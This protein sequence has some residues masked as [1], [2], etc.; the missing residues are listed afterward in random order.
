M[1]TSSLLARR[2]VLEL[3]HPLEVAV[4]RDGRQQPAQLGVLAHVGLAEQDAALGIEPGGHQHR[5]RVEHVAG[6][7]LRVVGDARGVQVDDAVDRR[8][9]ALLALEVAPDRADVVAE[10]LAPGRLDA[11]ED[12]HGG[13]QSRDA[14][15]RHR[16][17]ARRR[18]S[19]SP[20]G[21]RAAR[22][23]GCCR[24][25]RWRARE[26]T[27]SPARASQSKLQPRQACG[28]QLRRRELRRREARRRRRCETSTALD[29]PVARPG[30]ARAA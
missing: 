15:P 7:R 27:C 29:R 12:A 30:A 11:A 5:R 16:E 17:S 21:S 6:Q 3:R 18:C 20:S 10:V 4:G 13:G 1:R 9:A 28:S 14:Q 8:I 26:I 23:A 24:P 25:R 19:R 22:A 2:L